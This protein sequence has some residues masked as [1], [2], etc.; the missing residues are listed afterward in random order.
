MQASRNITDLWLTYWV[1]ITTNSSNSTED[2]DFMRNS[3]HFYLPIYAGLAVTNSIITLVRS[4][5]FAY[6]GIKA[7]KYIHTKLLNSVFYVSDD[8]FV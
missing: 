2:V 5:L 6:A 4:F 1:S 7:A 8:N 3:T